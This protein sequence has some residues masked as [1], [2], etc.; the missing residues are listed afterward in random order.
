MM[1]GWFFRHGIAQPLSDYVEHLLLPLAVHAGQ[2]DGFGELGFLAA[3]RRLA[4]FANAIA[5]R[6]NALPTS[7]LMLDLLD[8]MF[9][10]ELSTL[11][12]ST[13]SAGA[14]PYPVE[15]IR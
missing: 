1:G 9:N 14:T 13:T 6:E 12:A 11:V 3:A 15:C 7:D 10:V 2:Q 4:K 8:D 5:A